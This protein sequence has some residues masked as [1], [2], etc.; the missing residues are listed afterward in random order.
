[1]EALMISRI[2]SFQA[3]LSNLNQAEE[4]E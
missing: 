3:A 4:H 1:L 2:A